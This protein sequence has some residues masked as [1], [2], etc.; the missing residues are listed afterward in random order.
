MTQT[1]TLRSIVYGIK[2]DET[3][4]SF[5]E[6]CGHVSAYAFL[7]ELHWNER[8]RMGFFGMPTATE[9]ERK[10]ENEI[11]RCK[12]QMGEA[13]IVTWNEDPDIWTKSFEQRFFTPLPEGTWLVVVDYHI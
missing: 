4:A 11:R 9:C 7:R 13:S 8:Q 5:V 3:E 12:T 10:G 2:P 6:R 1:A